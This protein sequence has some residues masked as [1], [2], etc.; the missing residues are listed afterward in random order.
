MR[1]KTF[2]SSMVGIAAA[3]SVAGSASASWSPVSWTGSNQVGWY[4][5]GD[6]QNIQYTNSL[7]QGNIQTG[8][9]YQP[10]TAGVYMTGTFDIS[11][12]AEGA[13]LGFGLVDKYLASTGGYVWQSGAYI[14]IAKLANGNV[15][16]GTSDGNLGGN[17][18]NS[19]A[20]VGGNITSVD[21]ALTIQGGIMSL[22][23]SLF[24]GT[25]TGSYGTITTLNNT[26]NG[27]GPGTP[28][29]YSYNYP[30]FNSGAYVHGWNFPNEANNALS[31]NITT[32]P[33]PGALALLG[34]AG[35]AG[36][37]RRR[38]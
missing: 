16:I 18:T 6:A 20:T 21:F 10:N 3:V 24:S 37:R 27:W 4:P 7:G 15:N 29:A 31:W 13:A 14:Y 36:G 26:Y 9:T 33:A 32:V 28:P 11:G 23:S 35:L 17:L 34:V 38:A 12:M 22:T 5:V 1:N 8:V 25:L 19:Q 30:E 2:I